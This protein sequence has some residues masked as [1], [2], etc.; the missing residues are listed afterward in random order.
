MNIDPALLEKYNLQVPRYTSYPTVP[1]WKEGID[2]ERWKQIFSEEFL[3]NNLQQGTSYTFICRF[4]NRFALIA[5]A[6]RKLQPII[7]LKSS[8]L[9]R[10]PRNGNYTGS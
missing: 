9:K 8:M 7:T 3:R 1:F 10:Y 4:A 5:D 2:T 6:T